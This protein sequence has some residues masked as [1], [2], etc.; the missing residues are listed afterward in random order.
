MLNDTIESIH[1]NNSILI[2]VDDRDVLIT[3]DFFYKTINGL[4]GCSNFDKAFAKLVKAK[5]RVL[6][7]EGCNEVQAVQSYYRMLFEK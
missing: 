1:D 2:Q 7:K 5:L 3:K 6:K 4:T